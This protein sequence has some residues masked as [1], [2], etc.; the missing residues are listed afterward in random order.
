MKILA[1]RRD[2]TLLNLDRSDVSLSELLSG[3]YYILHNCR[4]FGTRPFSRLARIAFIAKSILISLKQNNIIDDNFYDSLLLSVQTVAKEFTYD[5]KAC[6]NGKLSREE[7]FRR[8]GH[9][10]SGTYDITSLRYDQRSGLFEFGGLIAEEKPNNPRF[11]INLRQGSLINRVLKDVNFGIDT[12]KLVN[13]IISALEYREL[14]KFEFTKSLSDSIELIAR[15]GEKLGISRQDLCHIDFDLLMRFRNPEV[16][17]L[18][19][20]KKRLMDSIQRH[21]KEKRWYENIILPPII[22]SPDDFDYVEFYKSHPEFITKKQIRGQIFLVNKKICGYKKEIAGKIVLI[23][24]ADPGY[25]WIF[26]KNPL[27]I[28]TKYGGVASH[29]A[30]RCAEFGLPAVIGCGEVIYSMLL[31]SKE[32][33]ID[34]KNRKLDYLFLGLS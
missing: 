3:I 27:A 13:F 19:Y 6:K 20:I 33:I 1:Y 25:D 30:I 16:S 8:Y 22:K 11:T 4:R 12:K 26:T 32:I 5:F 31:K 23:E 17:D 2:Q 28:V 29:M 21:K 10:R 15:A 7:F 34:C 18:E 14:S 9:L 24:N